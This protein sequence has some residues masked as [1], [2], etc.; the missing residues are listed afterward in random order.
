MEGATASQ[1][2]VDRAPAAASSSQKAALASAL[3]PYMNLP[4]FLAA[5]AARAAA[6]AAPGS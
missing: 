5:D 1:A 4:P 2:S 3:V 6:A